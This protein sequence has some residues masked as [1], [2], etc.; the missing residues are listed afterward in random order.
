MSESLTTRF[1]VLGLLPLAFFLGQGLHY[2]QIDQCGH[3]LWMCNVG[4][5]LLAVGLLFD[6]RLLMRVA[7]I[8]SVPGL[9]VWLL[10]V[11]AEWF[12]YATLDWSAVA[13]STFAHVGG[14]AVGLIVLR[15]IRLDRHSWIYAVVWY[16]SVQ[17]LSWLSTPAE[18]NVNLSHRIQ[19][20]WQTYF[21]S[22]FKFWIVLTLLVVVGMWLLNLMLEKIWPLRS[23]ESTR[24]SKQ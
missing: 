10:Y 4:N 7:I 16:L 3:L 12:H 24:I 20:G 17:F 2:W 8:W 13:S 11:V 21:S 22:Y 5:L 9:F 1:R 18:L 14:L 19:E 6:Q 23:P 15:R